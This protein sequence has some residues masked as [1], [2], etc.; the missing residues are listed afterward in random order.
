MLREPLGS[1]TKLARRNPEGQL[2]EEPK[3]QRGNGNSEVT[4]T[5]E[6]QRHIEE[7][8]RLAAG[9]CSGEPPEGQHRG[10][11]PT[12]PRPPAVGH[13]PIG[14][15]RHLRIRHTDVASRLVQSDRNPRGQRHGTEAGSL[16]L[17]GSSLPDSNTTESKPQ[18][19][20]DRRSTQRDKT[21]VK[22]QSQWQRANTT[23]RNPGGATIQSLRTR[24]GQTCVEPEPDRPGHEE[25]RDDGPSLRNTGALEGGTRPPSSSQRSPQT[26]AA[27]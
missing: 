3:P 16:V 10:S 26:Y 21:R 4:E 2:Q 23:D 15:R 20:N 13:G 6:G 18:R 5:P 25:I 7:S 22:P 24:H 9:N 8:G 1:T 27:A 17:A 14:T 12:R 19:G 11:K